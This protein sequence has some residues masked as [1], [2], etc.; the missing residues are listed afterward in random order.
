MLGEFLANLTFLTLK[1]IRSILLVV[2]VLPKFGFRVF[3]DWYVAQRVKTLNLHVWN[4]P[5]SVIG[6]ADL[7]V[8][9]SLRLI[10][11]KGN[12]FSFP[13]LMWSSATGDFP[14]IK[15]PVDEV[16]HHT[17][18]VMRQENGRVVAPCG[19]PPQN[20]RAVENGTYEVIVTLSYQGWN[21]HYRFPSRWRLPELVE[22]G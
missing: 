3:P 17:L 8:S 2:G 5:L 22:V 14:R 1:H 13:E 20:T 11:E 4:K 21:R 7:E 15:M 18:Q 12:H 9:A 19:P 10:N 6:G 16:N